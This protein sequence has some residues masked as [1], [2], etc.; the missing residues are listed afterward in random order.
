MNEPRL[1]GRLL[2]RLFRNG[3]TGETTDIISLA[4]GCGA[5]VLAVLRAMAALDRAGLVDSRRLRLT[6]SGLALAAAFSEKEAG[7]LQQHRESRPGR[8]LPDASRPRSAQAGASATP[9]HAA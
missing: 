7:A 9:R 3:Q 1:C 4:S 8:T 5:D 6:L 2:T